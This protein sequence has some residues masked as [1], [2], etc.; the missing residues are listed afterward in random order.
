MMQSRN[1]WTNVRDTFRIPSE[2]A[3]EP[4]HDVLISVFSFDEV[5]GGKQ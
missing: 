1:Q 2:A 4:S 3:H 5:P